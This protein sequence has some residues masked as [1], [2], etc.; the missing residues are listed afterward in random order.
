[1]CNQVEQR[2]SKVWNQKERE[3]YE[4][5]ESSSDYFCGSLKGTRKFLGLRPE[6]SNVA[7]AVEKCQRSRRGQRDG[8]GSTLC[9]MNFPN[10]LPLVCFCDTTRSLFILGEAKLCLRSTQVKKVEQSKG[11][12]TSAWLEGVACKVFILLADFQ[13]YLAFLKALF[14]N[15][16]VQYI[17]HVN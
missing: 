6:K 17:Y 7:E 12:I 14:A 11:G 3:R 5:L 2:E 4:K 13:H 15:K 10:F 16:N 8:T 9:S 1:M